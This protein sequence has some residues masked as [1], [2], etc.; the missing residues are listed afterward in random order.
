LRQNKD[1]IIYGITYIDHQ[2]KSVFN[3]SDLGKSYSAK[4][5]LE[6]TGVAISDVAVSVAGEKKNTPQTETASGQ[7][8]SPLSQE[9]KPELP[10]LVPE[11]EKTFDFVPW[12]LKKKRKNK[13]RNRLKL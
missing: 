6:R 4:M 13:K 8:Q 12:Q 7:E 11:P 10:Q 9:A 1:G 2:T 3:G 5:I